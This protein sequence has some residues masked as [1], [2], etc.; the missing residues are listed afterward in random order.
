MF[1][2]IRKRM[3]VSPPT[4]IATLALVFAM[5]G[6]AYA[7]KKYLITSTK[8]IS[9]SVL[10]SL[11]GKAGPAGAAGTQGV[12]GVAG[13]PGPGGAKGENG[14]NGSNG[15]NGQSVTGGA[16]SKAECEAG[17]VKYTSVSGSTAVC[18][19]KN[20]TTGFTKTLPK[21]ETETGSWAVSIHAENQGGIVP[22]SFAIPLAAPIESAKVQFVGAAGNGGTCPGTAVEPKAEK[23]NLCVYGAVLASVKFVSMISSSAFEGGAGRAGAVAEFE[24]EGA[25]GGGGAGFGTW[26]V[27]AE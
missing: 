14:A 25:G 1:S 12:P 10:K 7:A 6:G 4:V 8:Q 15:A 2:A 27:T 11:Q 13:A 24:S 21:G 20:G 22:I 18:N 17:G 16:A 23:G 26:A 9:P 3:R 5:T 19:G